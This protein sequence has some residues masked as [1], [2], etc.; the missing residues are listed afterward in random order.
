MGP[1]GDFLDGCNPLH[2]EG[3]ILQNHPAVV[4]STRV[5]GCPVGS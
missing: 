5:L 1:V 3:G 2:W 4:F